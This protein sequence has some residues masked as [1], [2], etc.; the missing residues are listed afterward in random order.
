MCVCGF[1]EQEMLLTLL[2]QLFKWGPGGLVSTGEATYAAVTSM[3]TWGAMQNV[4]V[5]QLEDSGGT[6]GAHT[7]ICETWYNLLWVTLNQST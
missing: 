4:H 3:G 6:S 1:L 2:L 7:F 5:S